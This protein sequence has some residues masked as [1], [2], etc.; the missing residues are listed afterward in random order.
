MNRSGPVDRGY[1]CPD[2]NM[3]PQ[4]QPD[5][6]LAAVLAETVKRHPSA[7]V[8]DIVVGNVLQGGAG[9]LTSRMAEL[10]AGISEDVPLMAINRQPP[11][12]ALG[13]PVA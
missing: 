1:L 9:A 2:L 4:T 10:C 6:L 7:K 12:P 13:P 3:L 5:A 11:S 8:G